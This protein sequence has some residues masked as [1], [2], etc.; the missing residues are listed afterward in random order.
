MMTAR[1]TI[2]ALGAAALTLFLAVG[3]EAQEYRRR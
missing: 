3:A 2:S 1:R